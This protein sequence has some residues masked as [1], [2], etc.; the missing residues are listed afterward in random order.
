MDCV[1][2]I[3]G[4][5][6]PFENKKKKRQETPSSGEKTFTQRC[7]RLLVDTNSVKNVSLNK[8]LQNSQLTL[9]LSIFQQH[10]KT[11]FG[12]LGRRRRAVVVDLFLLFVIIQR[13]RE[14]VWKL[15]FS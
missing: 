9:L 2:E 8:Q 1:K 12:E 3:K 14:F 15:F 7:A 10:K 4:K 5:C 11:L 13:E 6:F